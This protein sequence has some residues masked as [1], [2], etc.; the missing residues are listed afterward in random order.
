MFARIFAIFR[1][2][3]LNQE[4]DAELSA[5]LEIVDRSVSPRRLIMLLLTGFAGFAL[6]LASLEI[7]GV[8]S[9]SVN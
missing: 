1:R 2:Q 9:Y 3:E 7:Y 4:L 6:I 5:H 8:I